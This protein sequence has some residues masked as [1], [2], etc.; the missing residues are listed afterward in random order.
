V[1][2]TAQRS[3]LGCAGAGSDRRFERGAAT[4]GGLG[5][6]GCGGWR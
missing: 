3:S 6:G 1:E 2:R 5:E 4:A